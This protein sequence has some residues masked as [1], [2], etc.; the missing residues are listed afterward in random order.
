MER[1]CGCIG[2]NKYKVER[3]LINRMLVRLTT[4]ISTDQ[5]V[6]NHSLF[7]FG[8]SYMKGATPPIIIETSRFFLFISGRIDEG[9]F[10]RPMTLKKELLDELLEREFDSIL[11][12]I[13]GDFILILYDKVIQ[14]LVCVRDQM[15]ARPIYYMENRKCLCFGS[16]IGAFRELPFISF[17]LDEQWI[18]DSLS[19]LQSEKHR[20]PYVGIKKIMPGNMLVFDGELRSIS[21]W[22]L[23]P[24][25][26][27]SDL[28]FDSA[29][30]QF[31]EKFNQSIERRVK[32]YNILGCELSGGLDSSGIAA[33]THRSIFPDKQSFYALSHVLSPEDYQVNFPYKDELTYS[34]TLVDSIGVREHLWFSGSGKGILDSVKKSFHI[35]SGPSQQGFHFYSD[36]LFETACHHGIETLFSGFGGDEGVSSKAPGFF[37]EMRFSGKKLRFREELLASYSRSGLGPI[38]AHLRTA[39]HY[40]ITPRINCSRLPGERR[41]PGGIEKVLDSVDSDF[42]N[43]LNILNRFREK[44]IFAEGDTL[45]ERQIKQLTHNHISQRLEYSFLTAKSFGIAYAYPLLDID[46]LQF[47]LDLPAEF[48]FRNG[49]GRALFRESLKGI[50]PDQIRLREDKSGFTIPSVYSRISYDH[51]RI[52]E[53]IGRCSTQNKFHYLNYTYM[54]AWLKSINN[55]NSNTIGNFPGPG[56]FINAI[57]ILLLQEMERSGEFSSGIQT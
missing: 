54:L 55:I 22:S 36:S 30:N 28:N 41:K 17:Q 31:S 53:L 6:F 43:A 21:Y 19:L 25:E 52:K 44:F 34:K 9:Q 18:A 24:R 11:S 35:Q 29:V 47:Y 57:Q 48:K 45:K 7:T 2:R 1:F 39:F 4:S 49:I 13:R 20:T 3:E 23:E 16:E 15:G 38:R 27:L 51:N 42:L 32:G 10:K 56:P 37:R 40:N 14:N 33:Y 12:E 26:D 50:V 46:L 8:V 5:Y